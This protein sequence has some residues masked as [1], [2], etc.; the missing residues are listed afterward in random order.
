MPW[1]IGIVA[2][3]VSYHWSYGSVTPDDSPRLLQPPANA[4]PSDRTPD[5][6]SQHEAH[7]TALL[8]GGNVQYHPPSGQTPAD[9]E[10]PTE[11]A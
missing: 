8:T 7:P 4:V 2:S 11:V 9:T 6:A 10:D 1:P 5:R 3:D